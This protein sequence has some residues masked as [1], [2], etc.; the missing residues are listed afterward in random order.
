MDVL[1]LRALQRAGVHPNLLAV[2]P[3]LR[4]R[5]YVMIYN[6]IYYICTLRF[7]TL[8]KVRVSPETPCFELNYVET[9]C[10]YSKP[11]VSLDI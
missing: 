11:R 9:L 7:Q 3:G 1:V 6:I 10:L 5:L 4:S 2:P 8:R